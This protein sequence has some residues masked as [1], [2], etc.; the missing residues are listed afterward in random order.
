MLARKFINALKLSCGV[1]P[2]LAPLSVDC[3]LTRIPKDLRSETIAFQ[4]CL[5]D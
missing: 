3:S 1:P 2:N 5:D 4:S